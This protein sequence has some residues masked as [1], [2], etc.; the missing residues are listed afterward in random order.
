M[1]KI[2]LK[3][4][5]TL[6]L[7]KTESNLVS[8]GYTVKA[9]SNNENENQHGIAHLVEHMMFKGTTTKKY[10]E[11][12]KQI[13]SVGGYLNAYTCQNVTRY[14][15]TIPSEY[16]KIGADTITDMI[17]NNTIPDEE[18]KKEKKVVEEEIIMY[19][20]KPNYYLENRMYEQ[21]FKDYH[22]RRSIA[23]TVEEVDS[24][25]RDDVINF[26]SQHYYPSN[27][28]ITIVGGFDEDEAEK[29]IIK[30]TEKN[31]KN[32]NF[33]EYNNEVKEFKPYNLE[34]KVYEYKKS[35][36]N[37]ILVQFAMFLPGMNTEDWAALTVLNNIIGGNASSILYNEIREK[38]GLCY[39]ISSRIT[40]M[41]DVSILSGY[42]GVNKNSN[43]II[44][45]I[46]KLLFSLKDR[47]T[48]EIT[49]NSKKYVNGISLMEN[50]TVDQIND[51]ISIKEVNGI[52][53]TLEEDAEEVNKVTKQDIFDVIDKYVKEENICFFKLT[54]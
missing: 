26:I 18:L 1:K 48:D 37:Q 34:S 6:I 16:W 24:Y 23:G 2:N 19:D 36:I 32:I 15:C 40:F 47:I 28:I 22:N 52:E 44:E 9:G 11:I 54:K 42:A 7:E 46:K 39:H 4:G 35:D 33:T 17:Y 14:Y 31:S 50:E 41:S 53:T 20:D 5:I 3:N 49:E 45:D 38:L 29:Y 30:I 25:T 27:F 51:L 12:N 43:T 10:Y 8:F 21:L 13:E